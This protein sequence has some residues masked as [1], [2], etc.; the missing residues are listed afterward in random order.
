LPKNLDGETKTQIKSNLRSKQ[1]LYDRLKGG[2]G[3]EVEE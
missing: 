1:R 3:R 2:M